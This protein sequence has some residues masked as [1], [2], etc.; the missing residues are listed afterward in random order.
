[1][2]GVNKGRSYEIFAER[3]TIGR[4]PDENEIGIGGDNHISR[5]AH[6]YI[7]FEPLK[8]LFYLG[9]GIGKHLTYLNEEPLLDGKLLKAYDQIQLGQSK[10]VF[11]PFC[12]ERFQWTRDETN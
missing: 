1:V 10:L 7:L 4:E 12:G 5:V 9:P 3:N 2:H 8:S 6:A 11:V